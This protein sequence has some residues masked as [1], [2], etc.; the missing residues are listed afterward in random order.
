MGAMAQAQEVLAPNADIE[1]TIAGQF[2]AFIAEDVDT[3]WTF[4]S[5][6]I[7]QLFQSPGNFGRMVQQG[8]P[9]VWNPGQISFVDLQQLGSIIVQR[10]EVIDQAGTAHM[11]GY[12]MVETEA[13]W[14]INAVQL[15]RATLCW[16]LRIAPFCRAL[17]AS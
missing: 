11:L 4:A 9:M 8:Y 6:T 10:V 3:A 1:A 2:E 15:L 5:P 7:Q 16:R 17:T 13:G 14:R 12:Q